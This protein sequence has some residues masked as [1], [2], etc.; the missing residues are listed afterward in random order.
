MRQ[1]QYEVLHHIDEKI[2][3][4]NNAAEAEAV[5]LRRAQQAAAEARMAYR[6]SPTDLT[7]HPIWKASMT[8]DTQLENVR[9]ADEA[10]K[11]GLAAREFIIAA[12][13]EEEREKGGAE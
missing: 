7:E 13:G 1:S 8:A 4:L 6:V 11:I 3:R 12:F 5:E 9:S 2:E 10:V